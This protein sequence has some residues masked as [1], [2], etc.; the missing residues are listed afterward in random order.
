MAQIIL[1]K[2]RAHSFLQ[3]GCER[4]GVQEGVSVCLLAYFNIGNL[5]VFTASRKGLV[6]GRVV[7]KIRMRREY[8]N[9]IG[10]L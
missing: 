3:F 6:V 7:V 5:I 1:Y 10:V 2:S 8:I 9:S 4:C